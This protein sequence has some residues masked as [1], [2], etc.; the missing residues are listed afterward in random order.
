MVVFFW[1]LQALSARRLFKPDLVRNVLMDNLV[2]YDNAERRRI[3]D[4]S[5][6][7]CLIC[8]SEK[9][10]ANCAALPCKHI[11]CCACLTSHLN[12]QITD[13]NVMSLL[14]PEPSC[15]DP[16]P[17]HSIRALVEAPMYARYERL[18]LDRAL[19]EVSTNSAVH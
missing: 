9:M 5:I 11:F 17:Q 6:M 3:F 15:K 12:V 10:G 19:Q 1:T 2:M 8:F 16:L 7:R 18:L 14:C 4:E 13:G